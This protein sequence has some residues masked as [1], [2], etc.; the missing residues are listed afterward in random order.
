MIKKILFSLTFFAFICKAQKNEISPYSIHGYGKVNEVAIL[1]NL[2]GGS[3][4]YVSFKD[5]NFYNPATYSHLQFVNYSI[6]IK[7][8]NLF[9]S[10]NKE[11]AS[12]SNTSLSHVSIGFPIGNFG[13]SIGFLPLASK[14]YSIQETK[15]IEGKDHIFLYRGNGG[16]NDLFIGFSYL[17]E[18]FSFGINASYLFGEYQK[19]LIYG[20]DNATFNTRKKEDFLLQ[21]LGIKLGVHY[22]YNMQNNYHIN[23]GMTYK[24]K[25]SLS[26][27]H[28]YEMYTFNYNSSGKKIN[29]LL[30]DNNTT[31]DKSMTL[32]GSLTIGL[33]MGKRLNWY[34]ALEYQLEQMN[35]FENQNYQN[36]H[37]FSIAGDYI[38][39]MMSL[40]SY[41]K[42]VRYFG[43]LH[44][45]KSFLNIQNQQLY[46]YG[47]KMG[48]SLPIG[49]QAISN[50]ILGVNMGS[51]A[52]SKSN[53]VN[54]K[55]IKLN[56]QISFND[57]WF[58][59]KKYH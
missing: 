6:G 51:F 18:G 21:G 5:I 41:W 50:I 44:Y 35:A 42:R 1:P 59:E 57:T 3:T 40:D 16:L 30:V 8:D 9:L 54:E 39:N 31:K 58:I 28:Q 24:L 23:M 47:V 14:G 29:K 20:K 55:Y 34:L 53:L 38:P 15:T 48:V 27:T 22:T 19:E 4:S 12:T 7:N 26:G 45:T 17:K 11:S 36:N 13:M 37:K 33:G 10:T 2:M 52:T 46:D 25:S 32:P 49:K 56:L 43:G